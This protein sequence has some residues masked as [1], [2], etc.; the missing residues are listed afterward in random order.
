[1]KE[2]KYIGLSFFRATKSTIVNTKYIE[3]IVPM[4]N[5]N[6]VVTLLNKEKIIISRRNVKE[7]KQLIGMGVII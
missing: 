5:R 6:L 3:K 7:F 4:L 2:Q 1:M